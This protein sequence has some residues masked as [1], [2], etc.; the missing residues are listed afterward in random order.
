MWLLGSWRAAAGEGLLTE[1][2]AFGRG[3]QPPWGD[4]AGR[5]HRMM[6]S[7]CTI[8]PTIFFLFV[9]VWLIYSVVLISAVHQ[10]DSVTHIHIAIPMYVITEY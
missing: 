1:A 3:T 7:H 8:F 5:K 6:N 4:S 10:S 9:E 2:K